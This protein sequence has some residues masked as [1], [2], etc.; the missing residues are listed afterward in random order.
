MGIDSKIDLFPKIETIINYSFRVI[1]TNLKTIIVTKKSKFTEAQ[2]VY[3]PKQV[4]TGT[5]DE[6][7]CSKMSLSAQHTM[8]SSGVPIP[9]SC[10]Q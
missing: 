4:E 5:S 2:I 8:A 3:A 6:E 9:R 7:V 1:V 10:L